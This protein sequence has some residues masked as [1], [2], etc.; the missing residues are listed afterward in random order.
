MNAESF[1]AFLAELKEIVT[2]PILNDI[3]LDPV[4]ASDGFLYSGHALAGWMA[5]KAISPMTKE[6]IKVGAPSIKLRQL[7]ALV[8]RASGTEVD[9]G[10]PELCAQAGPG[11]DLAWAIPPERITPTTSASVLRYLTGLTTPD[12]KVVDLGD[13]E[14]GLEPDMRSVYHCLRAMQ[15]PDLPLSKLCIKAP[16][17]LRMDLAAGRVQCETPLFTDDETDEHAK[18]L[19][20]MGYLRVHHEMVSRVAPA[21]VPRY[22]SYSLHGHPFTHT[23]IR[24]MRCPFACIPTVDLIRLALELRLLDFAEELYCRGR[25]TPRTIREL[26]VEAGFEQRW[27]DQTAWSYVTL[28]ADP[29]PRLR[30]A[31]ETIKL[32]S[33]PYLTPEH[34]ERDWRPITDS[35]QCVLA[36]QRFHLALFEANDDFLASPHVNELLSN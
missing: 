2:C 29:H 10:D 8:H 9:L 20:T 31:E 5:K 11:N 27:D 34:V 17:A 21:D 30:T 6:P 23:Y 22:E 15:N 14:A 4:I 3:P 35:A 13:L 16:L 7:V 18:E 36:S 1:E 28:S 26:Y 32:L 12:G 33:N 24:V 19:I 25:F